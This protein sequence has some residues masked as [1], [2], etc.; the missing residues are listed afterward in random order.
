MYIIYCLPWSKAKLKEYAELLSLIDIY[1]LW[2]AILLLVVVNTYRDL[3]LRKGVMAVV[4]MQI[5]ALLIQ[6]VPGLLSQHLAGLS[7]VQP[8]FF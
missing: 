4:I 1:W 7:I 3:T 6:I 2:H 5:V 8:F